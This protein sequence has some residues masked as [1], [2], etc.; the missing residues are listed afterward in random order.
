MKN[1]CMKTSDDI[2]IKIPKELF[3]E[4]GIPTDGGFEFY[5]SGGEIIIAEQIVDE[6][7]C[8]EDCDNCPCHDECEPSYDR[9]EQIYDFISALSL[10]E[11]ELVQVQLALKQIASKADDYD[12]FDSFSVDDLKRLI[13]RLT[14]KVIKIL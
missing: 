11:Q 12:P 8:D 3:E 10:E 7:I 2:T 1:K 13:I 14:L 6:F 9:Q 4:A 5:C